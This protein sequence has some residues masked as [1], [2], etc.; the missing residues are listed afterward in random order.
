MTDFAFHHSSLAPLASSDHAELSVSCHVCSQSWISMSAAG[1]GSAGPMPPP[2]GP[3]PGF[4]SGHL[5]PP[6][7]PP[8]GRMMHQLPTPMM[9]PPSYSITMPPPPGKAGC[10]K[11]MQH[12]HDVGQIAACFC[13]RSWLVFNAVIPCAGL[14]LHP[15]LLLCKFGCARAAVVS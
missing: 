9:P 11:A 3:P 14:L 1:P 12:V 4:P 5:L 15:C 8:P 2:A 13:Q 6:A 10:P 7:G